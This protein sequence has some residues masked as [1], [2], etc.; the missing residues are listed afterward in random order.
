MIKWTKH[1][2]HFNKSV[3]SNDSSYEALLF[4]EYFE[5]TSD[6]LVDEQGNTQKLFHAYNGGEKTFRNYRIDGFATVDGKNLFVEFDGCRWH[7][8]DECGQIAENPSNK[9]LDIKKKDILARHGTL[10]VQ[11]EC[12]W[13]SFR[14]NISFF[15]TSMPRVWKKQ[16]SHQQLLDGIRDGTL[17]GFAKSEVQSPRKIMEAA[18]LRGFFYP[19]IATKIQLKP[20]H[21]DIA[22]EKLPKDP[23]LTQ[24]F[25]TVE[26]IL[27][28]TSVLQFYLEIGCTITVHE[29][30]QYK[31]EKCFQPFVDKVVT[32]RMDAKREGNNPKNLTA[33]LTG[34]SSYGKTLGKLSI[35]KILIILYIFRKS[36]TIHFN[37]NN[38]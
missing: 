6:L 31:G 11:K 14:Q 5:K 3:L 16:D 32:L 24:V 4:L 18:R 23:V 25:N 12:K 38:A 7:G 22:P 33:K 21:F 2:D 13:L 36:S 15:E 17:Y 28:H 10:Y 20:E 29:F 30:V 8:C 35:L 34:N 37:N 26:P 1:D 9:W 27:L 19:P